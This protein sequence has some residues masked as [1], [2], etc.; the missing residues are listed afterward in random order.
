MSPLP[1][2]YFLQYDEIKTTFHNC[3]TITAKTLKVMTG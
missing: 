2:K 3:S 1:T